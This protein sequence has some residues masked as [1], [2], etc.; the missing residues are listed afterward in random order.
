MKGSNT[1]FI[2]YIFLQCHYEYNI[3]ILLGYQRYTET[4]M[5]NLNVISQMPIVLLQILFVSGRAYF[6]VKWKS[7][8]L[9]FKKVYNSAIFI[10]MHVCLNTFLFFMTPIAAM[11]RFLTVG[12][13]PFNAASS[14]KSR[15][16]F[17]SFDDIVGKDPELEVGRRG[18]GP[19]Q[20]F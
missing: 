14:F 11:I 10:L 5:S 13:C 1:I 20:P 16:G 9:L 19:T 2:L 7:T 17:E 8:L 4:L 3:I 12:S 18:M 6:L 15:T